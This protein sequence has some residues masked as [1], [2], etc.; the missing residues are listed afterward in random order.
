VVRLGDPEPDPHF[1]DLDLG[2]VRNSEANAI[3]A[4]VQ[5][6]RE[7]SKLISLNLMFS[8]ELRLEF[9][10]KEHVPNLFPVARLRR[11]DKSNPHEVPYYVAD[12]PKSLRSPIR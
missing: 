5:R 2:G 8:G 1:T 9:T 6:V 11:L 12:L 4:A 10:T 7:K 3:I